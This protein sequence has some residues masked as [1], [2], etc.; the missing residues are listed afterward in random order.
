MAR[1]VA[2]VWLLVAAIL[3]GSAL[4]FDPPGMA[5]DADAYLAAIRR[6]A[7]PQPD[8]AKRRLALQAAA[9]ALS[10]KDYPVVIRQVEEAIRQG[11]R[12][13][14]MFLVLSEAWGAGANPDSARA[15]QAAFLA[16]RADS[17]RPEALLRLAA[18]LG[19]MQDRPAEAL[20]ALAE[21]AQNHDAAAKLPDLAQRIAALRLRVGLTLK[22]VRVVSDDAPPRVC[23]EFSDALQTKDTHFEDYLKIEPAVA[24]AIEP[25]GASLCLTGVENGAAYQ[26][27]LRQGL[28]GTEG[29]ILH[30]DE[31][32][33]VRVGNRTPTVGFRGQ[34]FILPRTA[35]GGIPVVTVNLD[36]VALKLYRIN[37]RNLVGQIN[38][39]HITESLSG[40]SAREVADTQGELLWQ[41]R[42]AVKGKPNQEITTALPVREILGEPKPGLYI[43]AAEPAD[44]EEGYKPYDKATQWVMVSDLGLTS[45]RG[46]DGVTVFVRS[47]AS[48]KPLGQ[49]EVALLARNNAELARVRTDAIGRAVF[50]PGLTRGSG[51]N[52]PVAVMAY[53]PEGDFAVLDL[54]TAAFDLSDRGVGGRRPPGPLDS[55][56]YTDRGVYRPGETVN[57]TVLLRDDRTV[58]VEEFPLTLKVLRPNGTE[59]FSK[60]VKA[61]GAGG[62]ALPIALNRAAPMGGWSVEAFSDPKAE[63]IGRVS[64]QVEDFVPERLALEVEGSAP[65][66]EPGQPF[67]AVVKGRF[68]YGPPAA[69]LEGSAELSLQ[70]DPN[71]YPQHKGYAFG[72]AQETVTPRLI[73]LEF[74]TSDEAGVSRVPVALPPLPD[75]TRALRAEIRVTMAEP[76]GRPSR[77]KMT[78]PVRTQAFALGLKPGFVDGRIAEGGTAQFELI[79]VAPDGAPISRPDLRIELIRERYDYQWFLD[80]GRYNYRVTQRDESLRLTRASAT[81]TA[82]TALAFGPFDYGRYR[83][84]VSEPASGVATSLR[85]S[86]GWFVAAQAGDTPDKVEVAADRDAYQPGETARV[87]ITPPF[88]GEVL[89]TVGTDRLFETRVLSVPAEGA[90]VELPVAAEWGPGAYVTASVYRPPVHGKDRMPVRAIGLA[91]LAIDPAARTLGVALET[92][93]MMRPRQVVEMPVKVT[94]AAALGETWV[95]LAAVDEGILQLTDFVS[96][97]PRGHFFGKRALGLDIRDDYGRL[98]DT[99]DGPQGELRQGG[100]TGGAGLPEVPIT[101]VSLFSGPVRVDGQG[102]AR[103]KFALPPFN[104]QLRLMAVAFDK[105]RIGAAAT[106]LIVRDPLVAQMTLPRFLAPGDLSRLTLSLHNVEATAGNYRVVVAT[107]GPVA[108]DDSTFTAAL[109]NGE[110]RS[111]VLA[112]HGTGAGIASVTATVEGPDGLSLSQSLKMT[113]RPA[114]PVE[115]DFMTSQLAPGATGSAGAALLAPFVP[116][117][118]GA[119]LSY[120]VAPPFDVPGLL[121]ALDRFPYG[122]LEQLVSRALP[123]LVVNDV[124]L[125]LGPERKPDDSLEARVDQAIVQVLDKQRYDGAFSLWSSRGEEAPWLTAYAMEFLTR[126]RGG[127]YA[128]PDAPYLNG[129]TWLRQFAIDGGTDPAGLAGR[130]YALDVLSMAGAL[131]AGPIR[132][133][134]DAFLDQLPTPLARAQV[135]AALARIGDRERA[136][137]A[138]AEAVHHLAREHWYPDYGSTVRDAAAL[139]TVLGEAGLTGRALPALIDRLPAS[140]TGVKYTSTQEQAWLVLAAHTLMGGKAPLRVDSPGRALPKGD[141]VY[142]LPTAAELAGGLTVRNAGQGPIWQ[143]VAVYG[144]PAEPRPAAREGLKIKRGFFHRDGTPLD[145]DTVKQNDVFVITLEGEANTKLYHQAMVV[146]PLP[147]GWEI[148]NT[149]LGAAGTK[150][151]P[152]LGDLSEPEMAAARDD[153]FIAAINLT[154]DVPAFKLAYLVRAVTPGTYELPGA[155]LFDMYK[156]RFFARQAVGRISVLPPG[157]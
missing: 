94:G 55:F 44:V 45:F 18:V 117:T 138:A 111:Q 103:I 56:L 11:E 100:D 108:V 87:R 48:A 144:I 114:R 148:E 91:W 123:L 6:T 77:K 80:N 3:P 146:H 155:E 43:V 107:D 50:P 7:P 36:S 62:Y 4:A 38:G 96:P 74:P 73:E 92:P 32:Q 149:R 90:T 84:E 112:L 122:C 126:A 130:A 28:P 10:K 76:G 85:F 143:A 75:T 110:R 118:A 86:A 51:G 25:R 79:A 2:A 113:V 12:R 41:G 42:L 20:E 64:F 99:L 53:G 89:V 135:A 102:Y 97:D 106:K 24:L 69:G 137:A 88:A 136:E 109:D 29:L 52:T 15:L 61:A 128:V 59:F 46:A 70:P 23:L 26:L 133:F 34:A 82:P 17:R 139:V 1:I 72:L 81:A 39:S 83:L 95:T 40:W 121:R 124:A 71:P 125:A 47:F 68:L 140:A 63:P 66:I 93:E 115:T 21:L 31:T 13:P 33:K 141:P 14:E 5:A 57:L 78:V 134:N 154:E 19:E 22:Q 129:L 67:E 151:L 16:Y 127:H 157:P 9:T 49:I 27:T 30:Q 54:T 145:L 37:D 120:S 153:R 101:V 131:T 98:I 105:T 152:W 104:G 65:R 156:P 35:T 147:A 8:E 150:D 60:V 58:A 142:L 132:Y 119:S 116:G